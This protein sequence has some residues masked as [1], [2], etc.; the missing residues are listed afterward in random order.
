MLEA[1]TKAE[2]TDPSPRKYV[3]DVTVYASRAFDLPQKFGDPVLSDFGSAVCG[4]LK[5][6]HDAQPAIYRSPEV[7]LRA[8]WSYPVD[9]WNVGAMV[10]TY[11]SSL[12]SPALKTW[13]MAKYWVTIR[14]GMFSKVDTFSTAMI[15]TARA[16]PRAPTWPR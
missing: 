6:N 16:T 1:F 11:Q 13:R 15:P 5:R 7:M 12:C 9:I 4:D 3:G 14:Y 10:R 8:E 2:L